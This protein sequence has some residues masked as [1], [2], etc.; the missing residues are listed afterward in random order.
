MHVA[1][2]IA[3]FAAGAAVVLATLGS[4]VRTVVLPRG[5]PARIATTVF[6][7]VRSL[8]RLRLGRSPSYERRDHIMSGYAPL[9][10]LVLALTWLTVVL[11]GYAAMFWALTV[12]GVRAAF[13]T[14]GSSLLTLGFRQPD[15]LPSVVLV[16]S[17]AAIGLGLLAMVITYLPSLYAAFSRREAAVA[18]L[19]VRAGS[20]ASGVEMI[21]R[22]ARI[23]WMGGLKRIWDRWE[24]W[25]V[26]V[27]ETH[28]SFP[29]L[30][31]F[32]S[33]QPDRS[34]VTS[35][36]AVL[37]AASLQSS[38]LEE[39][40]PDAALCIRAGYLALRRVADFFGIT[41]EASPGPDDPISVSREEFDEA[42]DRLAAA[43]VPMKPDRDEA[44]RHFRGW[45][46]NYDQVLLALSALVMAPYAPWSSD[47]S[48]ARQRI[49]VMRKAPGEIRMRWRRG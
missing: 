7:V 8:F 31:F 38:S 6:L 29:A 19:E 22:F 45:R 35:A 10:L 26:E 40:D 13:V 46:I 41:Y 16:F 18:L 42:F 9:S 27:E 3:V 23:E 4:A 32:R 2:R 17:E 37:D 34:W 28:T 44:W 33:P 24:R 47:R 25:F 30:V 12:P 5:I 43:G 49:K 48:L 15:D 1:V 11:A 20:P 14:S 36:G 21:E 39:H